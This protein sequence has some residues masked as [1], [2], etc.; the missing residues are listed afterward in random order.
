MISILKR[1]ASYRLDSPVSEVAN[2]LASLEQKRK[3]FEADIE[4]GQTAGDPPQ[5]V[6]HVPIVFFTYIRT[7]TL[8]KATLSAEN[9]QTKI[10]VKLISNPAYLVLFCVGLIYLLAAFFTSPNGHDLLKKAATGSLI[11]TAAVAIDVISKQVV[12]GTF[13][14]C[15]TDLRQKRTGAEQ[16]LKHQ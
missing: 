2:A 1:N 16:R 5:F 4:G 11:C 6:F 10:T 13:E 14:R 9:E 8:L 7:R 3:Q 12:L 15:L